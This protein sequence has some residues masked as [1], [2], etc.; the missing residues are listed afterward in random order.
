MAL[1]RLVFKILTR[2]FLGL[3]NL[4]GHLSLVGHIAA[5]LTDGFD[6]KHCVSC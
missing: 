2:Y 1:S 6:F 4:G 3:N 5:T